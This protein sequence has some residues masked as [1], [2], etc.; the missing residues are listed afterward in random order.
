MIRKEDFIESIGMPD[1]GFNRT[2][3][4]A[5]LQ[6]SEEERNPVMKRKMTMMGNASC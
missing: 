6:I 3:D 2:M 4:D 5:L 1:E